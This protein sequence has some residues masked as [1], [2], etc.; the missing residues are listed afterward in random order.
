M[1]RLIL[2]LL[3]TVALL[4]GCAGEEQNENMEAQSPVSDEP[5]IVERMTLE[6]SAPTGSG[7][8][9][10]AAA[11]AFGTALHQALAA[12]GVEVGTLS[13]TFSRVDA[14]TADAVENGGVTLGLL[15]LGG[16]LVEKGDVLLALSRNR[17]ELS[18]GLLMAGESEYGKQLAWR[19][20]TSS[21]TA[22]EWSRA[23]IGAVEGDR[24]L[25][26][27][28]QQLLYA[29]AG[30]TLQE[31][32]GYATVEELLAAAKQGE[33]DAAIIRTEDA[34]DF[35]A[36]TESAALYEGT[37]VL[38]SAAEE[39][40][41]DHARGALIRAFLAAAETDAGK[42]LLEQYSCGGFAAV[43]EE[44]IGTMRT[45]AMWEELE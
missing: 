27:A 45:L 17:E 35:W 42:A 22:E 15:G 39:L 29:S 36:L 26:A 18:C 14:A 31:Y 43:N 2:L 28:A 38:S 40:Q 24:V 30:Y 44:E 25:I 3:C 41:G 23:K 37:V 21:L 8:G 9:F 12:E 34:E 16:A 1:K 32:R 10:P 7:G 19:T 33:V 11:N 20:K 13:V 5:I 6:C 4:C